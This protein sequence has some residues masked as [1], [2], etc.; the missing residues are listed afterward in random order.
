MYDLS[1]EES[2]GVGWSGNLAMVVWRSFQAA[3]PSSALRDILAYGRGELPSD[4][5]LQGGIF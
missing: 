5:E 3:L 2:S 4:Y 1:E